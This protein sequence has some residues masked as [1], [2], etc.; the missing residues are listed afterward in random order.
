MTEKPTFKP[1]DRVRFN[2]EYWD[3]I[4]GGPGDEMNK[5]IDRNA[6]Y[7]IEIVQQIPHRH[8]RDAGHHQHVSLFEDP[9]SSILNGPSWSGAFFEHAL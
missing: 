7:T 2:D 6:T 1:G 9:D 3:R 4:P 8:R 5:W